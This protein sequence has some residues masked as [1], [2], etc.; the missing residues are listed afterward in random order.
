MKILFLVLAITIAAL[1]TPTWSDSSSAGTNDWPPLL[2]CP[3]VNGDGQVA[4]G[5]LL[6]VLR[7]YNHSYGSP[8]AYDYDYHLL[9]DLNGNK[10]VEIG[11]FF[12]VLQDYS[13]VCDP[14]E[15]QVARAAIAAN[16]YENCRDA[17]ADG[18]AQ[19]AVY[20]PN[21]GIHI[22]NLANLSTTFDIDKPFGLVCTKEGGGT[23]VGQVD[24]LIGLWYILPTDST[25]AVYDAIAPADLSGP[26]Q[27][28]DE[29][30]EGFAG[31]QD[32]LPGVVGGPPTNAPLA[33]QGWHTHINLCVTPTLLQELGPSGTWA[34]CKAI[35]GFLL[36]PDYGWMLHLYTNVP[37]PVDR[38]MRWNL[39]TCFNSC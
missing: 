16:K 26:C 22:S 27:P 2:S 37:N 24:R 8:G 14:V 1:L 15:T 32:N 25:C 7:N 6:A 33:Q 9:Y 23:G 13:K 12:A 20:V 18:F 5:D 19:S 17:A 11:D 38:F 35:G 21:M 39:N 29:M 28:G 36:V 4:I 31:P 34:Q 30:P 10:A 3:D